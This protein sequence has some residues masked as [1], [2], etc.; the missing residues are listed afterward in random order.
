M[1]NEIIG[2]AGSFGF[3]IFLFLLRLIYLSIGRSDKSRRVTYTSLTGNKELTGKAAGD[4]S[5]LLWTPDPDPRTGSP[6]RAGHP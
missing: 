2:I 1:S 4:D 6:K 5:W 3:T